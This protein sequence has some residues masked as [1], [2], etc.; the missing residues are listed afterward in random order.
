MFHSVDFSRRLVSR[1]YIAQNEMDL[2]AKILA[3]PIVP[4]FAFIAEEIRGDLAFANADFNAA[5][6]AYQA[7]F[8]AAS[9]AGQ[10]AAIVQMKLV[11]AKALAEK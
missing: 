4:Q 10:E 1:V 11:E 7:A 3:E 5:V 6:M 2:A 8:D 9:A